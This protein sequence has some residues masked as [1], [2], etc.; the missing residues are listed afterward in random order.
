MASIVWR[1]GSKVYVYYYDKRTGKNAQ[2]DR[3][4]TKHWDGRPRDEVLQ[5]VTTWATGEGYASHRIS[6]VSLSPEDDL[7]KWW[8]TYQ[9]TR[10]S[11]KDRR[12]VTERDENR[13]FEG[14]IVPFFVTERQAKRPE[15]WH[16]LVPEFYDWL[17]AK[18]LSARYIQKILWTLGR[19]GQF[20]V[21]RRYLVSPFAILTPSSKNEKTTPLKSRVTPEDMLTFA[22]AKV[23]ATRATRH[24]KN[25]QALPAIRLDLLG[26]V[27][28]FAALRP[29]ELYALEKAD[30]I[31][32]AVAVEHTRTHQ[33]FVEAKL[34]TRLSIAVTK[35]LDGST[36]VPLLKTPES[37]A[38]VNIWHREAALMIAGLLSE[39]PDGRL[40]P[41]SRSTL[42][43]YWCRLGGPLL[44]GVTVH[45]LR[46]ASALYLGRT[47]RIP[48]TLLQEHMRHA[49]LDTTMLYIREPE[50]PEIEIIGTQDFSEVV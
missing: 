46:R 6:R 27:G 25:P 14:Y 48:P 24:K 45:D 42:D 47:V 23:V 31:T 12:P 2:V 3:E 40:F 26:L 39:M 49:E 18:H 33:G 32:G 36:S 29:E 34:G 21:Y 10:K 16:Q 22:R 15:A 8:S 28:Y 9:V 13:V 30:F 4:K 44:H 7:Q 50:T 41:G 5:E 38:V 20:L 1:R 17:V 11:M 35:T 43:K 19:F 37:A